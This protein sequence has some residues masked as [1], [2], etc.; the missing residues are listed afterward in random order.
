MEKTELSVL[1]EDIDELVYDFL[2]FEL[3]V[4]S[5]A[6]IKE[7]AVDSLRRSKEVTCQ[8]MVGFNPAHEAVYTFFRDRWGYEFTER[9]LYKIDK[10]RTECVQQKVEDGYPSFF[11]RKQ[12]SFNLV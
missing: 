11:R 10:S 6:R 5:K 8:T 9:E 1:L 12:D 7:V 2:G 3:D 4:L